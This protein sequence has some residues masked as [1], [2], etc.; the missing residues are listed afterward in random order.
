MTTT[1]RRIGM[2]GAG[3]MGQPMI[4]HLA[5]K[6]FDIRA[7]DVDP[8]KK[9]A[10]EARG[11]KWETDLATLAKWSEVVL[12]CVGYDREL[13]EALSGG[14]AAR[15]RARLA[16]GG[17]FHV[18]RGPSSRSRKAAAERGID[19]VDA[20]VCRGGKGRRRGR[21][22]ASSAAR[23]AVRAPEAGRAAP[24]PR[25]SSHPDPR[26][27]RRWQG[28]QHVI[29]W[30]CL[31]ANHE[32]LALAL[33]H[34]MDPEKLRRR[35]SCRRPTT[36][37]CATGSRTPWRGPRTTW[38]SCR[39]WRPRGHG[40]SPGGVNRELCRSSNRNASSSG[41]GEYGSRP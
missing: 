3:R 19:V 41:Y 21:F 36:T 30:S 24:S 20:T 17:A 10:V 1:A 13:R 29:M 16:G 32:A 40:A 23:R 14:G 37:C 11:G 4:G 38:R 15:P 22:S 35:C 9:A 2:I 33:R 7:Y 6:G 27:P 18:H 28:R 25:T 31:I 12:V 34:G 8:G 26:A 39:R 5:R